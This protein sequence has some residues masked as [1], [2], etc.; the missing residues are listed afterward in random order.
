MRTTTREMLVAD[1][2]PAPYNP[3]EISEPALDGLRASI[4]RWLP[5]EPIV[6]NERTRPSWPDTSASRCSP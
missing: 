2:V 4:E 3:R 1:L 6:W 5:F